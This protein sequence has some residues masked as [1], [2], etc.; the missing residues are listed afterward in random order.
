[1]HLIRYLSEM[2]E[3]EML[4]R[5]LQLLPN[6]GIKAVSERSGFPRSTV[7]DCLTNYRPNR[8]IDAMSIY[9]ITASFLK[10]RGINYLPLTKFLK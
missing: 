10:E 3:Q 8:R 2:K 7:V 5:T 6:G 4:Q 9:R 1:M